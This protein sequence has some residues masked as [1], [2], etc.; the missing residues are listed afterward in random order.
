METARIL[1]IQRFMLS[2]ANKSSSLRLQEALNS[3]PERKRKKKENDWQRGGHTID[4]FT[5][6][7]ELPLTLWKPS[8]SRLRSFTW[9]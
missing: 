7:C 4:L 9:G 3:T 2:E 5:Q 6:A 1:S 8:N